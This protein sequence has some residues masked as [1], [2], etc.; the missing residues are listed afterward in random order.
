MFRL[1]EGRHRFGSGGDRAEVA[2]QERIT[3]LEAELATCKALA[4]QR[5]HLISALKAGIAALILALGFALSVNSAPVKQAGA[6]LVQALGFAGVVKDTDAAYAAYQRGNYATALRHLRPLADQGDARA[7]SILGLMYAEG[8]GV[9]QDSAEAVTWYRVAADYGHAPP[10][11]NLGLSYANGEGVSQDYVSAHMW[12][13]LAAAH[14]PASDTRNH[15]LAV[16]N[17]NLVASKMTREQV[18]EAQNLA[19]EWKPR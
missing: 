15:D 17:R 3:A 16:R 5:A 6:E 19:R 12:F 2:L 18:A 7:Q 9:P 13:N 11:Y 8:Q 1:L 10:Q 4:G 14:F